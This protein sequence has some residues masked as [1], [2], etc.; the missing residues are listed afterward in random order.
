MDEAELRKK[1]RRL[2]IL[3]AHL[4]QETLA[5]NYHSAFRGSGME[6]DKVREYQVGDDV[7]NIDWNVTARSR[8]PH[9]K[10]FVE[11]RERTVFLLIDT[12]ASIGFGSEGRTKQDLA[13]EVAAVLAFSAVENGDKV[14][15]LLFSEGVDLY[16]PPKKGRHQVS[17]ILQEILSFEPKRG[18]THLASALE[19][20]SRVQRRRCVAFLVSDFLDDSYQ[21]ELTTASGRHDIIAVQL[22]DQREREL[23]PM[24]LIR[25]EDAE[26]G[27]QRLVDTSSPAGRRLFQQH[28]SALEEKVTSGMRKRKVDNVSIRTHQDIMAPLKLLFKKREKRR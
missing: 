10:S 5:G 27:E 4:V 19:F 21:D 25:L 2:Q 3:S 26:T 6:F 9:V 7:R 24:G 13:G 15:I 17:R 11:E 22:A 20:L 23:P 18:T 28:T 1:V 14:G 8:T 12:S 16:L